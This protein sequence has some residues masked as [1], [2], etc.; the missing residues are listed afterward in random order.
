[1][2]LSYGCAVPRRVITDAAQAGS[3]RA[4][5]YD[6]DGQ[7]LTASGAGGGLVRHCHHLIVG[8]M[9]S[10]EPTKCGR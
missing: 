3:N 1:M 8:S 9:C 10:R 4:F 6:A 5:T 7:L 2:D